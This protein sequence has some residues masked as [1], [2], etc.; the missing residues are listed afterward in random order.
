MN[1]TTCTCS[2]RDGRPT[3]ATGA[4][5][6][7]AL[8]RGPDGAEHPAALIELTAIDADGTDRRVSVLIPA[9]RIEWLAD[10]LLT[11]LCELAGAGCPA[12]TTQPWG[13]N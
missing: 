9:D 4:T 12:T 2:Y 11:A 1:S 6:T 8:A 10:A 7:P 13:A 5:V 3:T